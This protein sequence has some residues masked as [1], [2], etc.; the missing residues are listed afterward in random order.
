MPEPAP[1]ERSRPGAPVPPRPQPVPERVPIGAGVRERLLDRWQDPRVR[2]AVLLVAAA[3]AGLVWFRLGRTSQPGGA[4]AAATGAPAPRPRAY[5][6]PTTT[7]TTGSGEVVVHVAGAVARPGVVRVG[8]GAR[9]VDAIEA[10]GG[11]LPDAALD[12]LNLAAKL[13]DGERIAVARAGEPPPPLAASG[14][15]GASGGTGAG[16][17]GGAAAQSGAEPTGPVDLNSASQAALEELPGIGPALAQ[18]IMRY[19]E[20]H[21][22]FRSVAELQEVR[23]IGDARYA[24]LE[25]LVTV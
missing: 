3:V 6:P 20:E 13:V 18:A 22:G 1:P 12:Q 17:G 16:A 7:T 19:R 21:G 10:A 11:G 25:G 2:A 23:G 4:D 9:V 5:L 24:E 15:P 14:G 8:A